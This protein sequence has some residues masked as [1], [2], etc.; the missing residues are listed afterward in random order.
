[1]AHN[2]RRSIIYIQCVIDFILGCI[3]PKYIHIDKKYNELYHEK[4]MTFA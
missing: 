3:D 2:F 4:E 1:M